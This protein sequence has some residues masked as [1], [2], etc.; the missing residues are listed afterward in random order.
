MR[1]S[2][3]KKVNS[4]TGISNPAQ[5]VLIPTWELFFDRAD[6][7]QMCRSKYHDDDKTSEK[8]VQICSSYVY[9]SRLN[10]EEGCQGG[11]ALANASTMWVE[12]SNKIMCMTKN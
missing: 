1:I 2:Y 4:V 6:L 8:L 5:C 10:H 7:K 3:C 9:S 11:F 12:A